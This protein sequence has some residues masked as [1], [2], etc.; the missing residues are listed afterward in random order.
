VNRDIRADKVRTIDE[1]GT[2]LGILPLDEALQIA[3]KKER[4]LVCVS[5][6]SIPPVCRILDYG[7]FKYELNKREKESRKRHHLF[8]LKE[9]KIRPRIDDHDYRVKL[10]RA[11]EFLERGCKLRLTLTF[12][13]RE[14]A[15]QELGHQTLERMIEDLKEYGSPEG[16]FR[17]MGRRLTLIVSPARHSA[18]PSANEQK[19]E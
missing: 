2:Q 4:D 7:K 12:R 1:D 18:P 13:G 10:R 17:K 5:P 9:I 8:K 16:S 6:Q 14:M 15:H 11:I 19:K 3:R